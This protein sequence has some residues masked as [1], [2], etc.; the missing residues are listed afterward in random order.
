MKKVEI[1]II[2]TRDLYK[3]GTIF[4]KL[5]RSD[6]T[7]TPLKEFILKE[8]REELD[9]LVRLIE[10]TD[11]NEVSN[12]IGNPTLLVEFATEVY[13]IIPPSEEYTRNMIDK[14]CDNIENGIDLDDNYRKLSSLLESLQLSLD[15]K[16]NGYSDK[17]IKAKAYNS[18]G[19]SIFKIDDFT[20]SSL[21][22]KTIINSEVEKS[23][24]GSLLTLRDR[25]SLFIV[26]EDENHI[27]F[28]VPTLKK[29]EN[30][31]WEAEFHRSTWVDCLTLSVIEYLNNRF[32]DATIDITI[33]LHDK[34]LVTTSS[35][36]FKTL[37]LRKG[38]KIESNNKGNDSI[39]YLQPIGSNL[40]TQMKINRSLVVFNHASSF[41]QNMIQH[42]DS[43]VDQIFK[44][45]QNRIVN[46]FNEQRLKA[47]SHQIAQFKGGDFSLFKDIVNELVFDNNETSNLE[48]LVDCSSSKN[49][50]PEAIF[51]VNEEVN[52]LIVICSSLIYGTN[53]N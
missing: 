40:Y 4:H 2:S 26:K 24:N 14:M 6:N 9:K 18:K 10:N 1:L 36:A 27:I 51:K 28:A 11:T 47:L 46:N 37:Y 13:A 22:D 32:K 42:N 52:K 19:K 31:K 33:M 15:T 23:K 43:S 49:E 48:K 20:E 39:Q 41:Y 16:I 17:L 30:D 44:D 21:L 25:I 8:N 34:D 38:I 53:S 50:D 45:F 35:E 12:S 29:A 5:K 7:S 3:E